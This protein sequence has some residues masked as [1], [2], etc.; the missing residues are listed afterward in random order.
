MKKDN[1][2][3]V[4]KI[5]NT[6]LK[7]LELYADPG[8]YHGCGFMFDRPTGGFDGDFSKDPTGQYDRKMPGKLAR[9][10]IAKCR[11][12]AGAV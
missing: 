5:A 3:K 11:K 4:N 1:L 12:I 9:Q 7:A 10:A 6:L 2:K 8:F